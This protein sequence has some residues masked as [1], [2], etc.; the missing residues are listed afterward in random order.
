[1]ELCDGNEAPL[2]NQRNLKYNK[3]LKEEGMKGC[4]SS[5]NE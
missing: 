3:G 2:N 4:D 5:A 1:M